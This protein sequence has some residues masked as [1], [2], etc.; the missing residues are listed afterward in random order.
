MKK[1]RMAVACIDKDSTAS[2]SEMLSRPG[3]LLHA[4]EHNFR[5]QNM[6]LAL[7]ELQLKHLIWRGRP[8]GETEKRIERV[9]KPAAEQAH[10]AHVHAAS[11]LRQRQPLEQTGRFSS[12][13]KATT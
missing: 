3:P 1:M 2:T 9:P 10:P 6:T 5:E 12:V 4:P 8:F 7:Y 13:T 11:A